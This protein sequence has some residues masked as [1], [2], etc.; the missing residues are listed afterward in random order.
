MMKL[1]NKMTTEELADFLGVAKQTVNRW[2]RDKGWETEK[3]PGIKGGR[4]RLIHINKDVRNFIM[5]TPSMRRQLN[6]SWSMA[7]PAP[8][9]MSETGSLHEIVKVLKNMSIDEQQQLTVLLAREGIRGFLS[10]LGIAQS[11][12]E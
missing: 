1:P 12:E 10:R 8:L 2:I 9:Y 7:E 4:A 6:P 11:I 5:K 3:I